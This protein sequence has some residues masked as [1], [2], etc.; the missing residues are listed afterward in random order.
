MKV[1]LIL[2][3]PLIFRL[4]G[5]KTLIDLWYQI[6]SMQSWK[7]GAIE[8]VNFLANLNNQQLLPWS[9]E[10]F[11]SFLS[12]FILAKFSLFCTNHIFI[13]LRGYSKFLMFYFQISIAVRLWF[14]ELVFLSRFVAWFS[15]MSIV[16]QRE[17]GE[18]QRQETFRQ[19]IG[20]KFYHWALCELQIVN[21]VYISWIT[22]TTSDSAQPTCRNASDVGQPDAGGKGQRELQWR[23]TNLHS[24]TYVSDCLP[25][26][27]PALRWG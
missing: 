26:H 22:D 4:F 23:E 12:Q 20:R 16:T 1:Q 10:S 9:V 21:L 25:L 6:L 18:W 2:A 7:Y 3:K 15:I 27:Q 11:V 13:L 14:D 17:Q 8:S 5:P 24:F 19:A